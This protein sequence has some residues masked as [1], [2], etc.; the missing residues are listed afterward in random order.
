MIFKN[1]TVFQTPKNWLPPVITDGLFQPCSAFQTTTCGWV[2]PRGDGKI[3]PIISGHAMLALRIERRLL[4]G[5]VVSTVVKEAATLLEETQGFAP[6]RRQIRELRE[7]ALAELTPKAFRVHQTTHLWID[8][9]NGRIS[10]DTASNARAEKVIEHLFAS[11]PPFTMLPTLLRKS[12]ADGM[13]EWLVT[14]EEPDLFTIDKDCTLRGLDNNEVKYVN[15]TL[16]DQV[17]QQLEAG[18][19]PTKLALT[20]NDRVS[21][22]LS[23]KFGFSRIELLDLTRENDGTTQTAEERF[24]ADFTIMT[25]ELAKLINAT[26]EALGGFIQ[27]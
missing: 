3:M 1:L 21:F 15:E 6:G 22:A 5:S 12:S 9:I 2:A 4:P 25:G 17:R 14:D 7:Q 8:P 27:E 16:G 18:K 10:I 20:Y 23:D 19:H 11:L 13:R 26:A 24:D